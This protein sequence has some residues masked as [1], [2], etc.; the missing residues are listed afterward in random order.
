[1]S[2]SETG[3][4]QVKPDSLVTRWLRISAGLLF[5][6]IAVSGCL[7]SRSA[8]S[9]EQVGPGL[10]GSPTPLPGPETEA[11]SAVD[12]SRIASTPESPT[13]TPGEPTV[14]PTA[15]S[16]VIPPPPVLGGADKIAYLDA[17]DLW[18]SNLDGSERTRLT[19]DGQVKTNLEW[20]ADGQ[21]IGY[22][23]EDKC[24]YRVLLSELMAKRLVCFPFAQYF[25]AFEV[26]PDAQTVA[27]SIDNWLYLLPNDLELLSSINS[28]S[29]LAAN[30]T[31]QYFDPLEKDPD[32]RIVVKFLRWSFDGN[33]LAFVTFSADRQVGDV[34][35]IRVLSYNHCQAAPQALNYFPAWHLLPEAYRHFPSLTSFGWDGKEQFAFVAAADRETG[36]GGLF[37]YDAGSAKLS[38]PVDWLGECCYRD[39]SFSPDGSYLL[40]A[41]Q[42]QPPDGDLRLYLSPVEAV[43]EQAALTPL[44]LPDFDPLNPPGAVLR[45]ALQTTGP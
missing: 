9:T 32:H 5:A 20:S 44:P 22:I 45:P 29:D 43:G 37:L 6:V 18:M 40:F 12:A 30:A 33:R 1:M 13:L 34:S 21:A 17:N 19:D 25:R 15:A 39:P 28:H 26:S 7:L 38:T 35:I 11:P 16:E 3:Q 41:F 27:L 42:P 2:L 14:L 23:A 8:T 10:P 36:L 24:Q 31:C 4:N